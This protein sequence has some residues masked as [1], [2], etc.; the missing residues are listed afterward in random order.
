M[1]EVATHEPAPG[2]D[3]VI[4]ADLA[5]HGMPGRWEQLWAKQVG[6]N[7]FL[8]MSLPFFAQ[9]IR[10]LDEVETDDEHTILRVAAP[11]GRSLWRLATLRELA[12][13]IHEELHELL[14]S[15]ELRHEWLGAGYVSVDLPD[16]KLPP[17]LARHASALLAREGIHADFY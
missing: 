6:R 16:R 3:Y 13:D 10:Y 9:G 17:E 4:R 12:D 1:S 14:L 8:M 7:R 5:D 11:G 15:L 2:S